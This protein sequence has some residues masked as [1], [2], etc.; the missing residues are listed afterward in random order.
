MLLP[1][2]DIIGDAGRDIGILA[3][4]SRIVPGEVRLPLDDANIRID[5]DRSAKSTA[6]ERLLP[7]FLCITLQAEIHAQAQ[8]GLRRTVQGGT[9]SRV[10]GSVSVEKQK[11]KP[12]DIGGSDKEE[13]ML[14]D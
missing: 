4:S 7:I 14:K 11:V 9:R 5:V 13:P 12:Q 3:K 8:L 1:V 6:A 2:L 10:E